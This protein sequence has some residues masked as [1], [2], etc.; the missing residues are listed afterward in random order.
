M[1]TLGQILT[2]QSYLYISRSSFL[3]YFTDDVIRL[4]G[5]IQINAIGRDPTYKNMKQ[6][7]KFE[8]NIIFQLQFTTI[9]VTLPFTDPKPLVSWQ[10]EPEGCRPMSIE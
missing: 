10:K 3:L 9:F 5:H 8:S 2:H 4:V 1:F 6:V 7:I